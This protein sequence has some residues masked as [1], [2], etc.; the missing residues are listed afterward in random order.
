[1]VYVPFRLVARP[2]KGMGRE[3]LPSRASDVLEVVE[4]E[5]GGI[6][7]A[8]MREGNAELMQDALDRL[9]AD[10]EDEE[11]MSPLG[12]PTRRASLQKAVADVR[13]LAA[14]AATLRSN[15]GSLAV[16]DPVRPS[17]R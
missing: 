5:F 11:P 14:A 10:Y 13:A 6:F 15:L 3:P 1:S 7:L 17:L 4:T 9:Q 16:E 12:L 8:G 2:G